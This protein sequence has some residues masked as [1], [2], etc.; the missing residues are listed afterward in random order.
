[1]PRCWAGSPG[2]RGVGPACPGAGGVE[3]EGPGARRVEPEGP[4]ARGGGL[5][6][7]VRGWLPRCTALKEWP[8]G[9][10]CAA[11]VLRCEA[12]VLLWV[13]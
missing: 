6:A 2:A 11:G 8:G 3:P 13:V 7:R 5:S 4:G 12:G 9:L 1:M 10:H